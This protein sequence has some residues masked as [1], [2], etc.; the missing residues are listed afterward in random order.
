[1]ERSSK[2]E[3]VDR[4]Y[5]SIV[6]GI[7]IILVVV[8]H[9]CFDLTRF[10]YIF[11]LPLF[12]FVSGYLYNEAKY[13]DNPYLNIAG[14]LKSSWIKYVAVFWVLIWLHNF[15]VEYKLVWI[16]ADVY[17]KTDI[18]QQM[19]NAL[20]GMGKEAFGNTL[21]FVPT[22][23][24]ASCFLGFIVTFSR[25]VHNI[26]KCLP[27]KYITQLCLI[28]G[29]AVVGYHFELKQLSLPAYMHVSLVVMP[30]L[31]GG[32]LLRTAKLE[33]K[34]YLNIIVAVICAILVYYISGKY[35]FDLAMQWVYPY[36]HIFA[37]FG[38]YMCLYVA[39]IIQKIPYVN[40]LFVTYGKA[41]F[42][43]MFI[44]LPLCRL[45]DWAYIQLKHKENFEELYYTISTV[46]FPEKFELIYLLL[47]LGVSLF[48]YV[49]YD[50][51]VTSL[52]KLIA[53]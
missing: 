50:K 32:Y 19:T 9:L 34:K 46:I 22:S 14:R 2:I 4:E 24:F 30:F 48:I 49:I 5:W 35:W 21:W 18:L 15:F 13:G 11:H 20:L 53:K 12:F 45:F 51:G 44:H 27:L 37:F 31:W 40:K 6:K 42:W 16:Y 28:A 52:K 10:I 39:K 17:S 43:L 7:G 47:G 25:K 38:I 8:G 26:T 3:L 33:Y 29:C 1:M 41:S 36:M 23:V